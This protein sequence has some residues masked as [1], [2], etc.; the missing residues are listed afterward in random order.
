MNREAALGVVREHVKDAGLV[1][2]M[3]AV[4]AAMRSYAGKLSG[5]A[6]TW[7]LAGLLHDFD[8]EIHPDLARHP[9]DGA[10]LLRA[11]CGPEDVGRTILAHNEAGTGVKPVRP[12][13][14]AL[15]A[16]D[17]ITGLIVATALVRPSKSLADV[18]VSSVKK[19]YKDKAFAAGVRRDEVERYTAAFSAACFGGALDLWTHAGNVLVAMQGVA[20]DL[21]LDGRL[22]KLPS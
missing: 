3:L 20:A 15:L 11:R 9:R 8:W 4:E 10:P 1:R 21:G 2:H 6:E 14:H 22:S 13:D 7:G 16:C 18:E 12:E 19:K 5:D 17:E